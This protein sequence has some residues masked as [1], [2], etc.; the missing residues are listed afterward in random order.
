MVNLKFKQKK[1]TVIWL[2]T[3]GLLFFG[4]HINLKASNDLFA[5]GARA[6]G[7]GNVSVS[8]ADA[9]SYANNPAGLAELKNITFGG[10]A[11]NRFSI[12]GLGMQSAVLSIPVKIG[13]IGIGFQN[14]GFS[15]FTEQRF[16]I[17]YGRWFGKLAFGMKLNYLRMSN[18]E[19]ASQINADLGILAKLNTKWTLGFHVYNPVKKSFGQDDR[20]RENTIT[21]LGLSYIISDKVLFCTEAEKEFE[22][23]VNVRAGVEYK[24]VE[25][26]F[27]RAGM[28]NGTTAQSFG[29]GYR[30]NQ[31]Q[32]D[33]SS[34]WHQQLGI[35]PRISIIAWLNKK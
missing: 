16:G 10:Y 34:T 12:P 19:T 26:F 27:I 20:I 14:M 32:I 29:L 11:D 35:T 25:H 8:N 13:G 21:R 23:N 2:V 18:N 4:S 7:M 15:T 6:W 28:G 31:L 30:S 22:Q 17:A 1:Q 9:F 5:R 3:F 24:P 33:V